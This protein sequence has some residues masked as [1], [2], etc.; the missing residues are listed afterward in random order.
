M[1]LRH[2]KEIV[3]YGIRFKIVYDKT[4]DGGEFS[5]QDNTIEIG[6]KS[7]KKDPLYTLSVISHELMECILAVS[8]CRYNN[9]RDTPYLFNFNHQQFENAIQIHA[10]KLIEFIELKR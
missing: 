4:H 8:G 1:K 7:E 2:P 3:I 9:S 5:C 10:E 6:C